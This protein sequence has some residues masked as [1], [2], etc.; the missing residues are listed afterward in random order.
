MICFYALMAKYVHFMPIF[1][2]T[3]WFNDSFIEK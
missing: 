2:N 1:Y 3:T